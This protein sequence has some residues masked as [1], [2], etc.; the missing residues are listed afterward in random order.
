MKKLK[1]QNISQR[2][3]LLLTV[4]VF[5]GAGSYFLASSRAS[6]NGTLSLSP[7]SAAVGLGSTMTVTILENS[8]TVPANAVEADLTYDQ[9]KLQFVSIDTSTSP[10]SLVARSS[11][12]SGNVYVSNAATTPVT[13]Q[14]TVAIV[15]FT[16]IGT[17]ST[18]ITFAGTSGLAQASTNTDILGTTTG[19]AY[20]IAD[21]TAP[22]V[23]SGLAAT[24]RTATSIAINWAAA[25]DNVSV[26]GYKIYRGGTQ[27]GTSTTTSYTD[28][29]L[30]PNN[31]YSY[32]VAAYDA[33]G[34]TSAQSSILATSTT[35]DTTTPTVPSGLT[36]TT[37]TLTSIKLGW[38]AATDNVSVTG[39]KIYRGGTQVGTSTTTSYTDTGLAP[40]SGYA[41]TVAAY[42]AA[43]N[44]SAQSAA[45]S[46][47]TLAD[48][49]PPSVPGGLV[50]PSQTA[51]TITLGWN[52][53]SDDVAVTGYKIYRGGTQVATSTTTS[54]TDTGL[55]A[56]THYSYTVAAY[57]AAGNTSAQSV[58]GSFAPLVVPGDGNGDGH[59]NFLDLSLL[60]SGWQSTTDLRTDFNHDG[61][62]N[63]LDLSILASNWGK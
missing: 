10:F 35:P 62:V 2:T 58:A 24:T 50:S 12:G 8:G 44:N 52:T 25:T 27:V 3:Y 28:N 14:Q 56:G 7:A 37:R 17:G 48:T 47:S 60:A 21:T 18:P 45:S 41:Y 22:G 20:T 53:A 30:T 33:A 34:N 51:S 55:T 5:A 1:F 19:G 63:F 49:T 54:Y 31:N 42:D 43:G 38:A 36:L 11:G 6:G 16:A 40:G 32:T 46:F 9:T 4:L 29:G 15:T 26:T 57:D 13:G 23:P 59:V 39:Y 61:I